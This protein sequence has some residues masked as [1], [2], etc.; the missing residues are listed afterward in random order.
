MVSKRLALA[1]VCAAALSAGLAACGG[2]DDDSGG[3]GTG[4]A[5]EA[6]DGS[7]AVTIEGFEFSAQPVAAGSSFEVE[8]RDSADHTFT[9]DDGGFDVDVDGGDSESVAAPAEAGTYAFHCNI[10]PDMTGELVVE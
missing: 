4:S 3:S 8:N 1:L 7:V 10:H 2:D 6:D 5:T 9:A